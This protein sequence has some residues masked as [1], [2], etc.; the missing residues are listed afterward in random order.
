[1][2]AGNCEVLDAYVAS[3]SDFM[4]KLTDQEKEYVKGSIINATS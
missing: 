1:M 4:N 3:V 2:S